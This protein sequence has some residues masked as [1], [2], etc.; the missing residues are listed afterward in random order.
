M[1]IG[2]SLFGI[3]GTVYFWLLFVFSIAIFSNSLYKRLDGMINASPT[4][5]FLNP[6]KRTIDLI[7]Y[8]FAQKRMFRDRY[9]AIFHLLIFW[10]FIILAF[11]AMSMT[12]E[13]LMPSLH[14]G[15][16]LGTIGL[17]YQLLKD[18][19]DVG[20]IAGILLAAYRRLFARPERLDLSLDAWIILL[21]IFFVILTDLAADGSQIA[22]NHPGWEIWSPVS[23]AI[24]S[25]IEGFSK[26]FLTGTYIVAWWSHIIVILL[27]ANYLPYSKHFHV[28]T[29]L[30]NIFF[31]D[32][33]PSGKLKNIDLEKTEKFGV[34]TPN[35]FTWKQVLD[36]YTCTECG[37]C[38]EICPT[39]ITGK[40]L[41]PKQFTV[42]LRDHIYK[43]QG[44][45]EIN[46]FIGY[47]ISEETVW[48]CTTCRYCESA[49]PLFISYVDKIVDIRRS[50]V[51]EESRFPQEAQISFKGME[52]LG[53]PWSLPPSSRA[54]WSNGLSVPLISDNKDAEYLF[55]VGCAGSFEDKAKKSSVGLVKLLK[56]AGVSF[57][58][59]GPEETCT[60]D[61]ARRLG[62]EYLFQTL[63]VQNVEK[64][65][66][67]NVC[68]IV[69][70]CPHCYNTLKNEYPD[71]G[72][73]YKVFHSTELISDLIL[74]G[75][76]KFTKSIEKSITYHDPCYLG[77]HNEM[78]DPQRMIM[79][80]IKGINLIEVP[81][82][83]EKAMC[84]GAGGGRMWLEEKLGT[85]INQERLSQIKLPSITGAAVSCPFCSV[86]LSNACQETGN[87]GFTIDDVITLAADAL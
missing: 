46:P 60:G 56:N 76:L 34:K 64:L 47:S 29:A 62:N 10:G 3:S 42:D 63:A 30:P 26:A 17:I 75:R 87:E 70:N 85:R 40:P 81:L 28:F 78:Y 31:R 18:I 32:L 20:V 55:W 51:L 52:R 61:A 6:L 48:A 39:H 73:N 84:C 14:I 54:D 21:L 38:R 27:F 19:L 23:I 77:R 44:G 8:A 49:C 86:M 80:A 16:N 65:N 66:S 13:G 7:T 9:A 57:A 1:A 79:N 2:F 25:V 33:N 35:D 12:I 58:I 71:F 50:L 24:A 41:S 45:H 53:N 72:G 36:L 11:R 74:K 37:R 43:I 4:N 22:L 67:Y 5:Q 68:K 69:T 15:E 59:L 82:S 83:K